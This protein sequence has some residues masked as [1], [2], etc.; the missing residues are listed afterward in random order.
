[1]VKWLKICLPLQGTQVQSLVWKDPTCFKAT[2][3]HGT[4]TE[5]V[6]QSPWSLRACMLCATTR[7][8]TE[9][10]SR[11]S[12][13][14]EQPPLAPTRESPRS[15]KKWP[16]SQKTIHQSKCWEKINY[17]KRINICHLNHRRFTFLMYKQPLEFSIKDEPFNRKR[18]GEV[19][20]RNNFCIIENK[21]VKKKEN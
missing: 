18:M 11:C 2:N 20:H 16:H 21:K 7:K 6:L 12:A 15:A 5:P 1:M 3:P 9:M 14:R 8:A 4:T 19:R 13:T 10:R 17:T